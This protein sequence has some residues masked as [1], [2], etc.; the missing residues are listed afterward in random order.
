MLQPKSVLLRIVERLID[1]LIM[2]VFAF[3]FDSVFVRNK[4]KRKI[5]NIYNAFPLGSIEAF[6]LD[7]LAIFI[8]LHYGDLL[9][10]FHCRF[11]FDFLLLLNYPNIY[12]VL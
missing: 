11:V 12:Q 8:R 1:T 7:G 2:S 4:V 5:L 6:L 10:Y 3:R 9:T